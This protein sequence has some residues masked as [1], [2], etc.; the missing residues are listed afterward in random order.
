VIFGN[1]FTPTTQKVAQHDRRH[2]RIPDDRRYLP[3]DPRREF[4]ERVA[5]RPQTHTGE[6]MSED[7]VISIFQRSVP[8]EHLSPAM[9]RAATK[10]MDAGLTSA[11]LQVV[12]EVLAE[13]YNVSAETGNP[14]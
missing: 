14:L 8:P 9:E 10:L 7:N 6:L 4:V 1:G 13:L 12:R 5:H 2:Q 11:Q 3:S